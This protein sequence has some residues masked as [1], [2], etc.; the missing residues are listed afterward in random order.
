MFAV[1][2]IMFGV[3]TVRYTSL[4]RVSGDLVADMLSFIG[5][6]LLMILS[7]HLYYIMTRKNK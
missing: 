1:V 5:G 6:G 3:A 2:I 7:M 4:R